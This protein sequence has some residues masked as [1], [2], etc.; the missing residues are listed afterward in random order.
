MSDN[1]IVLTFG[2]LPTEE[3]F[4]SQYNNIVGEGEI[5]KIRSGRSALPLEGDYS[6]TELWLW[7]CEAVEAEN[8]AD[9]S[10]LDDENS[11]IRV[12]GSILYTLNVEWV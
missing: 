8:Q 1:W 9:E 4:H 2:V 11:P 5:Y 3:E 10:G 7:L 6:A 12:A